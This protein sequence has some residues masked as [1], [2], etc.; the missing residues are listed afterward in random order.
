MSQITVG[1]PVYNAMPYLPE[2]VESILRQSYAD[3]EILI[4]NDGSSDD[5]LDLSQFHS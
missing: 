1:I 2:S 5:S 4:I 3:F